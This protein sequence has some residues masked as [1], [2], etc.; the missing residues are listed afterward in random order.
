LE[1]LAESIGTALH[2]V[3]AESMLRKRQE[4]LQRK[5][6]ELQEKA[7]QLALAS[8]YKSEFL[9]N[10]SH[11]LRTPLNSLLILARL[12]VD[13]PD[14]TLGAKQLEYVRTSH[15]AGTDLLELINE[16]LDLAKIESGTVVLDIDAVTVSGLLEDAERTFRQVA[17]DKGL[18]FE[19]A[20]DPAVPPTIRTDS[21]RLQ[22]VLKNL[23]S[24]AFKFTDS[25][26]VALRVERVRSGWSPGH[27]DLDSA[28][29]V[30][31]F[32]VED[33]GIG[34]PEEKRR[35]IF[36]AF[37]QAGADEREGTGLGLSI[38]LQLTRLLHGEIRVESLKG[39]GSRFTVYLPFNVSAQA[40]AALRRGERREETLAAPGRPPAEPAFAGLAGRRVLIIDDDI[41]N[42]FA[43][44]GA[45]EEHGI[46]VLD[47]ESGAAG[48]EL[49][50]REPHVDA[51][52]MDMMMPGLDGFDSIRMIRSQP[53]FR[54]LPIVAVTAR[55]MKGDREK[56]IEA[57]ATDYIS[58]PV[59][60][61]QLLQQLQGCLSK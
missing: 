23:L 16:I 41:R 35:S 8:R 52:L 12:L 39:A 51:V 20:V 38:C 58:K 13:N 21:R 22:Q 1:Q 34:I 56:C 37:R 10:M 36:Q 46:R 14:G 2:A 5:N 29:G 48:L 42:V 57:G 4:E 54:D 43:L 26:S 18:Q 17:L 50:K 6:A 19:V 32:I 55:A 61:G 60:V 25:G 28:A 33:T 40:E 3:E 24:N 45:L 47:A 49:L 31:A 59:D 30:V 11:E 15:A 44:T 9:A 53:Q 27:A 7:E